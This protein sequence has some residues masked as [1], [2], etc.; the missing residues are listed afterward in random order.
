LEAREGLG[1]ER[2]LEREHL[3][4]RRLVERREDLRVRDVR[5]ARLGRSRARPDVERAGPRPER[6]ERRHDVAARERTH[7][8]AGREERRLAARR[9]EIDA[10][11]DPAEHVGSTRPRR[12]VA[13]PADAEDRLRNDERAEHAVEVHDE[14]H[15]DARRR[16]SGAGVRQKIAH[17][18]PRLCD[19]ARRGQHRSL[20][21]RHVGA[22]DAAERPGEERASPRVPAADRARP[23]GA[24]EDERLSLRA[25]RDAVEA[26]GVGRVRVERAGQTRYGRRPT[27]E[28]RGRLGAHLGLRDARAFD[29]AHRRASVA[30]DGVPVVALLAVLDGAVAAD[31]RRAALPGRVV[32]RPARNER[33]DRRRNALALERGVVAEAGRLLA[34]S[35]LRDLR[36]R[37][38]RNADGAEENADRRDKQKEPYFP[39]HEEC[40]RTARTAKRCATQRGAGRPRWRSAGCREPAFPRRR[41]RNRPRCGSR[42]VARGRHAV[43][44]C[45]PEPLGMDGSTFVGR[46][47]EVAELRRGLYD[48]AAGHGRLFLAVGE[49]GIG[50]TRLGDELARLAAARGAR[51]LRGRCW[52]GGGA[53]AY[54]PW[55]QILRSYLADRPAEAVGREIGAD[56]AGVAQLA[57]DLPD[58]VP[59]VAAPAALPPSEDERFW[60]FDSTTAFLKR[61]ARRE[62][63]VLLVDD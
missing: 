8:R 14:I 46:D 39:S 60:L 36:A 55:T 20:E 13:R 18:P 1:L 12:A 15:R 44:K 32:A 59:R 43:E 23:G 33:V 30:A 38:C 54:W 21:R 17:D 7:V 2:E 10:R 5:D 4:Q 9:E 63:L 29:A 47:R 48:A 40:L 56:A 52:E 28:L 16:S 24:H 6:A 58:A 35:R 53:P 27:A 41:E 25:S 37:P 19:P 11:R 51:V 42:T 57:G 50:K 31:G 34:A 62:P 61:A 26:A 45:A 22:A 3:A 49:P